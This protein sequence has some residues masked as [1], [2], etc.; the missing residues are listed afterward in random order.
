MPRQFLTFLFS[1]SVAHN[2]LDYLFVLFFGACFVFVLDI[3]F[4]GG[5]QNYC[6]LSGLSLIFHYYMNQIT[7]SFIF[8]SFCVPT[9]VCQACDFPIHFILDHGQSRKTCHKIIC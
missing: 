6:T 7:I 9:L 1:A 2:F 8:T 5:L 4:I 3:V